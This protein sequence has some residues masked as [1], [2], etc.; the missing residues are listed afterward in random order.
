VAQLAYWREQLR[1][2]LP[3]LELATDHPRRASISLRTARQSVALPTDLS[4][5]VR[6]YCHREGST[7]FMALAAALKILWHSHLG[8]DDV[9]VATLVANRHRPGTEALIG[10]LVN[11]VILRTNLGGDPTAQEVLRRV[12]ATT[13][14]A[15]AN[16]DLPFDDLVS[17]LE[18]ERGLKPPSLSPV[19]IILQNA[20]LRPRARS[21]HALSFEEA[22]PSMLVPLV[23][24]TTFD[25]VLMLNE[26]PHGLT[27]CCVYKAE[28]FEGATIT[29]MIEDFQSVLEGLARQPEQP[30]S[31]IRR[32]LNERRLGR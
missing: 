28:L 16:Q 31:A 2:P 11:T 17:T 19:M 12:R 30:L 21:G 26:G 32:S 13:L 29:R 4:E 22:N 9:R 20:T 10:P 6:R 5:A 14:A 24:A 7:V 23:M 3:G 27:G 18:C 25:V 8:E 15:Y 1:D